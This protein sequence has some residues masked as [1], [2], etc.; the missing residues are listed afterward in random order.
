[1]LAPDVAVANCFVFIVVNNRAL[2]ERRLATR[3]A[4]R[5]MSPTHDCPTST[6]WVAS[7]SLPD[8]LALGTSLSA[9]IQTLP[10]DAKDGM[11][12]VLRKG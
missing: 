12:Q 11:M 9:R 6:G 1:M 5:S 4:L 3:S 7:P 2:L 8:M 10:N